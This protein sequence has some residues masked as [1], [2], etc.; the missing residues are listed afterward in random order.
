MIG[1]WGLWEVVA[2]PTEYCFSGADPIVMVSY[3]GSNRV[4]KVQY[5]KGG[6]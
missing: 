4:E 1:K 5:V 3:D 6:E 2:T